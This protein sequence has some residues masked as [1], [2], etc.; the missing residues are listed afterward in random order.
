MKILAPKSINTYALSCL[1]ALKNTGW[2]RF[3]VLG[4]AFGLAHYHEYRTTKDVDAWWT[5][6]ARGGQR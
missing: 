4:G 3:I 2:G 5:N 6:D 1:E